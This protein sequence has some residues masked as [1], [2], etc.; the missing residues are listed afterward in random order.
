MAR[1][2]KVNGFMIAIQG[3]SKTDCRVRQSRRAASF[4]NEYA[5]SISLS[6]FA[7]CCECGTRYARV[8]RYVYVRASTLHRDAA[9]ESVC[10]PARMSWTT[11]NAASPFLYLSLSLLYTRE[12]APL[13]T[14]LYHLIKR[15]S[16]ARGRK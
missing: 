8:R 15:G 7:M 6:L 3:T 10:I 12:R 11:F 16:H 9:R 2:N 5:L 13:E 1:Y 4:R 14:R